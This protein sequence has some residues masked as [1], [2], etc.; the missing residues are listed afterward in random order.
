M[1]LAVVFHQG[2]WILIGVFV[3]LITM[4]ALTWYLILAKSAWLHLVRRANRQFL[5]A[6]W[7]AETLPVA[8]QRATNMAKSP[9][10]RLSQS[11][12][13]ALDHFTHPARPRLG[14]ACG[15]DEFLVRTLRNGINRET[16]QTA[17]GM[18]LL[19]SVG[20]TA[21]FV[22]LF[23]TVW[24]IYNALI[25]ISRAG[26]ASMEMVAG[27]LGEALVATAAGLAAAIPAVL[28]YNAFQRANR[29]LTEELDGF[30]HDLHAF[31][32]TGAAVDTDS[33]NATAASK[34]KEVA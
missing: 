21:P 10:A 8:R 25:E 28:A 4:S 30:A 34:Q 32:T 22:G 18:T 19:A 2:D 15:L 6:F 14:D 20:S 3:T 24:G 29:T 17:S 33:S 12:F 27:P 13:V 31:L 26:N 9:L 1:D 23:G 7:D 5:Q 11:A 16:G